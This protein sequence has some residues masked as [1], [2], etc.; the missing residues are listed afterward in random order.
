MAEKYRNSRDII[1]QLVYFM[2]AY[3]LKQWIKNV[4]KNLGTYFLIN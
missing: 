2:E 3:I 1:S 4:K